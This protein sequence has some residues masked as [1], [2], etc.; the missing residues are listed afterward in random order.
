LFDPA[1]FLRVV[2]FAIVYGGIEYRYVNRREEEWTK[3]VDSFSE[4]PVFWVISPYHLYLLLP[5][6][7]TASFALP[8]TAWAGNAFS[9]AVMED[10]A[11]FV[12]KG[13]PVAKGEWTTTLMGSVKVGGMEVPLWWPLDIAVAAALFLAPL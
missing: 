13:K 11:Y 3:K 5:L 4:K 6:F 1:S 10:V 9:L 2:V 8:L 7:V 12:W